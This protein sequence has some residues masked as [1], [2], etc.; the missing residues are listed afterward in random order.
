MFIF[1]HLK[2]SWL[3]IFPATYFILSLVF[4]H[5]AFN[6]HFAIDPEY[7]YLFNAIT[8]GM[9]DFDQIGHYDNPGTTFQLFAGLI[10]R[11]TH[12]LIGQEP[13]MEDVLAHPELYLRV[14]N[15]VVNFALAAITYFIGKRIFINEGNV[16]KSLLGQSIPFLTGL[17]ILQA[18]RV[19]PDKFGFVLLML[20]ILVYVSYYK[21]NKSLFLILS[22][23][24]IAG[25]VVTKIHFAP[26]M[27]VPLGLCLLKR[28]YVQ[29]M[30][31][32]VL[33]F[34]AFSLPIIKH[35]DFL[36]RWG[37]SLLTHDDFYGQGEKTLMN[38]DKVF[39]NFQKLLSTNYDLVIFVALMFTFLAITL[40]AK[41][42]ELRNYRKI[43]VFLLIP[44]LLILMLVLKH[45]KFYYFAPLIGIV[46]LSLL[47]YADQISAFK[48]G[49]LAIGLLLTVSVILS[50]V[51]TVN[52]TTKSIKWKKHQQQVYGDARDIFKASIGTDDL[53][54]IQGGWRG[55]AAHQRGLLFGLAYVKNKQGF[56]EAL[57]KVEPNLF[58]FKNNTITNWQLP[59]D[60]VRLAA[61]AD[62]DGKVFFSQNKS[63]DTTAFFNHFRTI[64]P[65]FS[66][67]LDF[68]LEGT[69]EKFYRLTFNHSLPQDSLTIVPE[70]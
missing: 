32:F 11:I 39:A 53:L 54:V 67:K 30:V 3:W 42:K 60:S 38:T 21:Q 17:M 62:H 1:K 7:I 12:L 44:G 55:G 24:I 16:A 6:F 28:D 8:C 31:A 43:N 37:I 13:F 58:W 69:G 26:V 9:L 47:I 46:G 61:F 33:G 34:V 48:K 4:G 57:S 41:N 36:W 19:M 50:L 40:F 22:G 63:Q 70:L 2:N 15:V 49:R 27:L 29:Y 25:A 14:I 64:H 35:L 45:Y 20:F 52:L 59:E 65:H 23:I 68:E 51:M 10:L 5:L 66:Y 56:S 18:S